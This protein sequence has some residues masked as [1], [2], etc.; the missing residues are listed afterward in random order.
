MFLGLP[1]PDLFVRGRYGSGSKPFYHQAKM[2][3]NTKK[4]LGS[5][6]LFCDFFIFEK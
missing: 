3:R 1:D 2:K 5:F 6:L 4:N